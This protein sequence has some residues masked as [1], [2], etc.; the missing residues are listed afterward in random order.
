MGLPE[1]M[2]KSCMGWSNK[3]LTTMNYL[4]TKLS[5]GSA[6]NPIEINRIQSNRSI[7]KEKND[8]IKNSNSRRVKL[9]DHC[10]RRGHDENNCWIK[11]PHLRPKRSHAV[12]IL[13][14]T[15]DRCVEINSIQ[16]PKFLVD[17]DSEVHVCNNFTRILEPES[18]Q[19]PVKTADGALKTLN[20]QGKIKLDILEDKVSGTLF[21]SNWKNILSIGRLV[22]DHGLSFHFEKEASV[23]RK[24]D[25]VIANLQRDGYLWFMKNHEQLIL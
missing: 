10:K 6:M 4:E 2:R 18:V 17:S 20:K 3:K 13:S 25:T 1:E 23:I 5:A 22:V 21:D 16:T 7:E 15:G 9:C 11:H 12:E 14:V 8:L 19:V 24:G